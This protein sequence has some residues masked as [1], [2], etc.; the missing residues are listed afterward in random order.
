MSILVL[1]CLNTFLV[2]SVK[3]SE[4]T[5]AFHSGRKIQSPTAVEKPGKTESL[6]SDLLNRRDNN[7]THMKEKNKVKFL[8]T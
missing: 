8:L 2:H 4:M 3:Y 5:I 7:H 6:F 1:T